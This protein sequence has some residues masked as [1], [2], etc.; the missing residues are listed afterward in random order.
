ML[1]LKIKS[2]TFTLKYITNPIATFDLIK[3]RI[4]YLT[5]YYLP[6]I[7]IMLL[8]SDVGKFLFPK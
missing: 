6:N 3:E 7:D 5:M 8:L 4:L 1:Y 2:P